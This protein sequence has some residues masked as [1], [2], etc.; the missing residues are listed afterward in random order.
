MI[1]VTRTALASVN[2]KI[3]GAQVSVSVFLGL[4][5]A[6]LQEKIPFLNKHPLL[7]IAAASVLVVFVQFLIFGIALVSKLLAVFWLLP[8]L[9]GGL[10]AYIPLVN[11]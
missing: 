1:G 7:A 6:S 10:L 5:R 4:V 11:K 8:A 3:Y 2:E 9:V